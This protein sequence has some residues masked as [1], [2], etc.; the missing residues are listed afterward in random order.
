VLPRGE[1]HQ[2]KIVLI[3]EAEVGKTSLVR[4]YV[5]HSFDPKYITTIGT[6]IS[7]RLEL[8]SLEDDTPVQVCL[9]IWDI[10]G[11][12]KLLDQLG[13]AYFLGVQGALAVFDV[14]RAETLESLP[15]WLKAARKAEPRIPAM[16]LGNKSD[17][18]AQRMVTNAEARDFCR[19]LG[20]PYLPTS[21]RTGLNVEAAFRHL[22]QEALRIFLALETEGG[23]A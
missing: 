7:K 21:A 8:L 5:D 11:S 12:K 23:E 15:F 9:N 17:L 2:C 4:Q 14:T 16:V 20:L 3:G 6:P 1:V 19:R 22:A 13:E 10:M 18:S